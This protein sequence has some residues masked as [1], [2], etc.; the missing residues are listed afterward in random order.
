MIGDSLVEKIQMQRRYIG[1]K[2][3]PLPHSYH[4]TPGV[5]NSGR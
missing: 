5:E 4:Q 1:K 2:Y 3:S